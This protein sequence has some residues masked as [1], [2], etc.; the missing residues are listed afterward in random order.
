MSSP[1]ILKRSLLRLPDGN[2]IE[3]VV[4]RRA[5]GTL[6][7]RAADELEL[8]TKREEIFPPPEEV[9]S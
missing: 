9:S 4:L 5:D 7:V 3:T 8:E 6:T 1:P 2:E